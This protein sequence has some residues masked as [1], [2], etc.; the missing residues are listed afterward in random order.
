[1]NK[2]FLNA[3]LGL[4]ILFTTCLVSKANAGIIVGD[5]YSDEFGATGHYVSSFDLASGPYWNHAL[6]GFWD[7]SA[8]VRDRGELREN[9]NHVFKATTAVNPSTI[10]LLGLALIAVAVP[11]LKRRKSLVVS[12]PEERRFHSQLNG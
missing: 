9:I 12:A 8:H 6:Y 1:M 3:G 7:V 10:A 4:F 2:K 5:L 11:R